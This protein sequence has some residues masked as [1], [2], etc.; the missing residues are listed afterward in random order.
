MKYPF[1]P[2]VLICLSCRPESNLPDG[3]V[4]L[5]DVAPEIR[6]ELRYNSNN[7]FM[8][9]RI[10]GYESNSCIISQQ[11]AEAL[12]KAQDELTPQG[13]YLKIFDA[14]RPQM[15]VDHFVKWAEDLTDT[16]NK[17][18]YYPNIPK[19]ELFQRGYIASRSGHTRGSTVDLTIV[20]SGYEAELDMGTPWDFFSEK[21]WP[22]HEGISP[23]QREHREILRNAMVRNGFRPYDKEWWH[24]T[25]ENEPYPDTY[26]NFP[27]K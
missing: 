25:L 17:A 14:Y 5:N 21:S 15:A 3:F 13:L 22:D 2:W 16:L 1:I 11:A 23:A 12:D 27:V 9:R 26:F 10:N 4:Y 20:Y 24:F 6:V 8:G 7:N 18:A 19:S